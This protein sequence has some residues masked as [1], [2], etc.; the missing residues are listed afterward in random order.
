MGLCQ[1]SQ[2]LPLA[3]FFSHTSALLRCQRP[4]GWTTNAFAVSACLRKIRF[5]PLPNQCPLKLSDCTEDLEH[6]FAG[7][8]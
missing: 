1:Y 7:W 2:A 3:V 4:N 8:Q 5:N 6:K